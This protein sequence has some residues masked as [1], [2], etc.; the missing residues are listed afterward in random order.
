[1]IAPKMPTA[2]SLAKSIRAREAAPLLSG[3][4]L[5]VV[6]GVLPLGVTNVPLL[7]GAVCR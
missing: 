1:M 7:V 6:V 4:T 5:P 3:A 2:A